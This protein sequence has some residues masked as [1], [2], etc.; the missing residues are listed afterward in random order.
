MFLHIQ[1]EEELTT[2]WS[3]P[4]LGNT[5]GWVKW[6]L[7]PLTPSPRASQ[8]SAPTAYLLFQGCLLDSGPTDMWLYQGPGHR[9]VDQG[10]SNKAVEEGQPGPGWGTDALRNQTLRIFAYLGHSPSQNILENCNKMTLTVCV[11]NPLAG[12]LGVPVKQTGEINLRFKWEN[13]R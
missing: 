11:F 12:L 8:Q 7:E 6:A 1:D 10:R 4:A 2:G 5:V 3:R 9:D 13:P